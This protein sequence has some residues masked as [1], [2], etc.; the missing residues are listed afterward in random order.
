V[1][2]AAPATPSE[3]ERGRLA[4][5]LRR[6]E[7]LSQAHPLWVIIA[8][9]VLTIIGLLFTVFWVSFIE[10]L[11]GTP[12]ARFSTANYVTLYTNSLV[13]GSLLNTL[14]FALTT[15]AVSL[16]FGVV[17][18]WLVERTNV[19]GKTLVYAAMSLGLLV[20]GFITAMGWLFL[21]HPRIGVINRWLMNLLGLTQAPLN[22]Q[23][24]IGMGWVQ[25]LSLTA[26]AFMLVSASFRSMDPALE[27]VASVHGA[28]FRQVLRRVF[29]PLMF[30]GILA[31]GLY[32]FTIGFAAF[33]VPVVIGLSGRVLTF[34][35]FVYT[36]SGR[37]SGGALPQ[38]GVV[39]AMS[40]LM[41]VIALLCSVWYGKVIKQA[42]QYRVVT[43]KGYRPRQIEL[44]AWVVPAWLFIGGYI[45]FSKVL[46]ILLLIWAACLPFF[47]PPSLEAVGALSLR[48]FQSIPFDLLFRG[49][50]HTAI[51]MVIVPTLVLLVSF[52]FSWMVVRSRSRWRAPLDFFAFLP[53]AIPSIIFGVGALFVALF[54]LNWLPLYGSLVLL[55]MVYVVTHVSF[56]TRL[57]N[58]TLIQ[59]HPEL[60]EASVMSGATGPRTARSIL[61]PLVWPALLNGWLW[62]ALL[63]YR[64]LT[65]ASILFSAANVTLPVVVWSTWQTGQQGTAAAISV[66]MM[67]ILTPLVALYWTVGRRQVSV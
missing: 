15:I 21:L 50:S 46:P 44:G 16:F 7:G 38:Y 36:A 6:F 66:L 23:S 51:L 62:M 27:E 61:V 52:A 64:E 47:Q 40:V 25:G 53:H 58:S 10:G 22:V 43:G 32:I 59:I 19:P 12:D 4:G 11:P 63:T 67:C 42:E 3:R 24:V 28:S 49:T 9:L 37:E 26:L 30:P 2:A 20:P 45:L 34:S 65:L 17:I 39:A 35:T 33:D 5:A 57:L 14:G 31:A 54:V 60:E 29:L 13:V 1:E 8:P 48:N 56:G 41:I 55:A 18:A